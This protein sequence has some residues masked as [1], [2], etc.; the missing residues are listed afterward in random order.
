MTQKCLKANV[1][2][3]ETLVKESA[4]QS[5]DI[6]FSLPDY[7]PDI[8]KIFKCQAVP[9]IASKSTAN[10]SV[11]IDG[12]VS[13]LLLY[14]DK[15]G[16]LCSYEYQYPFSKSIETSSD[17]TGASVTA[18]VKNEYLN[19]RAVTGRKVDIHGAIGIY[20]NIFKRNADEIVCD[21]DE[22]TLE[23]RRGIVPATVPMGY[24]EKYLTLEEEIGLSQN[25][26]APIKNIIRTNAE[27]CIKETKVINDKAVVKGEIKVCILFCSEG[28]KNPQMLKTTLPFS[29]VVDVTGVTDS[30]T[31]DTKVQ[32]ASLEVKPRISA[33][34]ESRSFSFTAKLLL[35]CECYC[36]NDI[37]VI[38]DAFSRKFSAEIARKKVNFKNIAKNICESFNCKK[39]L[40]FDDEISS[41][42]D[43]SCSVSS[44]ITRFKENCM[45]ISG[46]ITAA[47]IICN[48]KG[49]VIYCEK[50]I[51]FEYKIPHNLSDT[52][53]SC[54]PQINI[55]SCNFTILSD[56]TVELMVEMNINAA[57]YENTAM[58][59]ISDITVDENKPIAKRRK[60]AMTVYFPSQNEYVWDIA[61]IYS[62]SVDEIM[63]I[64]ELDSQTV[65]QR[66]MI[67]IPM[68]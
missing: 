52:N 19:C 48:R 64:N 12:T 24:A 18:F 55:G 50:P 49:D 11:T 10:N 4:E 61:R 58:E 51:D 63:K 33:T 34:G 15:E 13:I 68:G 6:E 57:I 45:T 29:Q 47:F 21:F 59:L 46:G 62:A 42:I 35:C 67:L 30:C 37:A 1:F 20:I 14:S 41:V 44:A 39:T 22:P 8:S 26:A 31:C 60:G 54:D 56:N 7:C 38:T 65:K 16:T 27:P 53:L 28:G 9:R 2:F 25:N 36:G 66:R 3:D 32:I 5:I 43:L 23:L 40:S 17:F